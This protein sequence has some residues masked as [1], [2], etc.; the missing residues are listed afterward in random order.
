MS[1]V[2]GR[3]LAPLAWRVERF[4]GG[5]SYAAELIAAVAGFRR[6]FSR[7]PNLVRP[8]DFSEHM[9]RLMLTRDGRSDLRARMTDKELVKDIVRARVGDAFVVPTLAVLRDMAAVDAYAFPAD[10]VVKPTHLSGHVIVR[11][12]GEPAIDRTLVRRW[13]AT[14]YY[15]RCREPVYRNLAPKVMVEQR[16]NDRERFVPLDFKVFCFHGVP[17]FVQV[18]EGRFVEHRRAYYS[19]GWRRLPFL[20]QKPSL[21][22]PV[23]RPRR[24]DDMLAA[25]ARL[26][27]GMS[28]LRVDFYALGDALKVG[29]LT[30]FPEAGFTHFDPP[31]ADRIAGRFFREPTLDAERAF[32][33][34]V[35]LHPQGKKHDGPADVFLA[36]LV[37]EPA[38][39][40]PV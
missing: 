1:T 38:D 36:P 37:D 29:E 17:A 24:L 11:R 19:P 12:D 3:L 10:C 28:F 27:D 6:H 22:R 5:R 40:R 26:S 31:V 7:W 15:D 25:A 21:D 2:R 34:L 8:R 33:G 14:N 30:H 35:P 4:L 23:E 39:R 32:A 13:F 20:M 9:A 16:L 18:D